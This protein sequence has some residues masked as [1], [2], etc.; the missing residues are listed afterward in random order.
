MKKGMALM[1]V[2]TFAAIVFIGCEQENGSWEKAEAWEAEIVKEA[3][4]K[5]VPMYASKERMA[6]WNEWKFGMFIHWGAW[7]QSQIGYIW[8]ITNEETPAERQKSFGLYKTFNPVRFD[9]KKWARAAKEAGMKYV[10]FVT[11]HHDGFCNFDTKY[12]PLKVTNPDCPWSRSTRPDITR[13][14]AEAFRAEGI[15][16]GFYFSHIDWHHE[17]GKYFSRSH[18]DYNESLIDTDPG[19]W[20]RFVEFEKGQVRELLTNYGDV[21]IFWFDIYWPTGLVGTPFA[22]PV[23]KEDATEMI[24]MMRSMNPELIINDRGT[25]VYGDFATPEQR[26]PEVGMPGMWEANLTISNGRGFWYKGPE[27]EYK[28]KEE[29]IRMLVDIASKGGNF[30]CNVGPTPEGEITPQE[31]SRLREM[32]KWLA[33]NGESIYGAYRTPFRHLDWG[34]CTIKG[35]RLYLH[36]FDWPADG[37]L[38]VPGLKNWVRKAY[39]LADAKREALKVGRRRGD[40]LVAVATEA[41]DRIDTVVVLEIEGAAE[42]DNT[43]RQDSEGNIELKSGEA[44]VHGERAHYYF[45]R[46]TRGGDYIRGWKNVEE[47]LSWDVAVDGPGE[48]DVTIQY[49]LT[50]ERSGGKYELA[51]AAGERIASEVRKDTKDFGKFRSEAIGRIRIGRRGNTVLSLKALEIGEGDLMLFRAIELERVGD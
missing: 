45:G 50:D 5:D 51:V 2:L 42:V 14:V 29:L 20:K 33:V 37:V 10:V 31:V 3:V 13:E 47:W 32:G 34:R 25:D 35:E 39:L 27:A 22:H 36:V 40:V 24:K 44:N 30:L 43:I 19:R 1:L 17:D 15:A 18:W 46:A 7:S 41:P 11:K 49:A 48:F 21:D 12:T 8:H 16:V 26:V 28:T 9:A 38:R 6:E 23:V 4:R